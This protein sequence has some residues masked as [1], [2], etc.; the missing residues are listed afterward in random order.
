V[1]RLFE[2]LAVFAGGWTL[3]AAEDICAAG[4]I[5]HSVLD[6]LQTLLD[7]HLIMLEAEPADQPRFGMLET[8][9]EYALERLRAR[10]DEWTARHRHASYF[11]RFAE[12]CA[13]GFHSA[14]IA[15]ADRD[16]HNIRA[17]LHWALDTGKHTLATRIAS[18][19]FWYWDTRGLLEEGQSWIAQVLGRGSAVPYPWRSRVRAYAS[20]MA[21]RRGY[22]VEATDLAG[23]VIDDSQAAAEDRALALRVVGL[24]ALQANDISSARPHFE[25]AL[26]FAQDNG[27]R[28]AVASAQFNLGL[29]LLIQGEPA[30]AESIF[31]ASYEP[32]EQQQHPRYTG[33]ALITFGYIALLRDEPQQA[34][35]MLRDGLRQLM[36]AQEM[37]FLLYGLL[38][39]A[40]F[41]AIRQWP[42]QAA[43]LFGATKRHAASVRLPFVPGVLALVQEHIERARDQSS[44]E[45]FE[46]ALQ[47]GRSLALDEAVALAQ[48][49][50]EETGAQGERVLGG[51]W[52]MA[53]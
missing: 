43:A 42:L 28:A 18:S 20:Y 5:R 50:V 46:G 49:L 8:I 14:E 32:W 3:E 12:L 24:A 30:E 13:P 35:A 44:P 38:A 16:Y 29:L 37:T 27:L 51:E 22:P 7:S 53:S 11:R 36:L 1:Q 26:A 48:S 23:I 15:A 6:G 17:A 45:L 52:S 25:R 39:C 33:V 21:Y 31:W 47:R 10:G 2:R 9:R 34:S 41:A 40:A 4:D 19:V